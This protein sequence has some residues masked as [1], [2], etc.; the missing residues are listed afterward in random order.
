MIILILKLYQKISLLSK[1]YKNS[2]LNLLFCIWLMKNITTCFLNISKIQEGLTDWW[3]KLKMTDDSKI[4][5]ALEQ[6]FYQDPLLDQLL[7][8]KYRIHKSQLLFITYFP[9]H[10]FFFYLQFKGKNLLY[11]KKC[12]VTKKGKLFQFIKNYM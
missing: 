7:F 4:L 2:F 1:N 12:F 8:C 10:S 6:I 9:P 5:F 3:Q 11:L